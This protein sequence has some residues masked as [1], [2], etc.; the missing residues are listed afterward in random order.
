[1][2]MDE[3]KLREFIGKAVNDWGAAES[4]LLTFVGDRLGLFKAVAET[5]GG[6][7]PEELATKTRTHPRM[8]R[9]WLSAQ[10]AGGFVSFN[11]SKGTYALPE[12][13]AFALTDD[14]GP[15]NIVGFY[16]I[17]AG[18]YKDQEKVIEAFDTVQS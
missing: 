17:L 4:A 12:E 6:L 8:I 5:S 1:M 9:E 7:T 11:P 13:L 16:Q 10:A 14:N 3:V 2:V 15:A 18:L